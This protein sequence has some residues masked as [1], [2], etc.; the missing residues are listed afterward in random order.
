MSEHQTESHTF[1][2]DTRAAYLGLIIGAIVLFVI[3]F[4][5]IKLTS[6]RYAHERPVA[7]SLERQ[8]GNT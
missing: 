3:L 6:A 8:Q 1:G 2:T 5:I 7:V 4:T